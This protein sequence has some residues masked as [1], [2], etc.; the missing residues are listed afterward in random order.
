VETTNII[1]ENI[2][3][4]LHGANLVAESI[5]GF[6]P[7]AKQLEQQWK[8]AAE[9]KVKVIRQMTRLDWEAYWQHLVKPHNQ[10]MTLRCPTT[11]T[12][13]MVPALTDVIFDGQLKAE[14]SRPT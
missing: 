9:E 13:K 11:S 12:E 5:L 3:E 2:N 10:C 14:V 1:I 8:Q 4:N 6:L 7:D